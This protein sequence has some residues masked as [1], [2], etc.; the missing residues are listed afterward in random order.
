MDIIYLEPDATVAF[1]AA[2]IVRTQAQ[3]REAIRGIQE[4][5]LIVTIQEEL[6]PLRFRLDI[7][8]AENASLHARIKTTEAIK[9]ITRKHERHA[10]V[11]IEPQLVV[12]QESQRQD[13]E[14]FRK[15]KELEKHTEDENLEWYIQRSSAYSKI[16]L[17]SGYYQLRVRE[18][19]ILK[20]VFRTQYGYYEFR[21]K[22][23]HEEHLKLI[24]ELLK[25][26]QFYAKFSKYEFWI[27]KVQFLGH[28][29]NSQGIHV[30]PGDK[31]EA[32]FQLIKQKLCS[33]PILALPEGSEDFIVY[34]DASIKGLGS[35]LMQREKVIAYG[36]R[37]LKVH[38]KNYTTHD[39]ELGA[40]VFA[41][42][43]WRH[44]LYGTKCTVKANIVAD[45]VSKKKQI[46]PLQVRALVMAIS[47]DLPKQILEAQ[48]EARKPK[49]LKSEDVGGFPIRGALCQKYQPPVCWAN[50][51][52][53]QLIGPKLIHEITE[54]II[55]I[56]QGIQAARD[57]QRSYANVRRKLLEFQVL[58]KV[59]TVSYRLELPQQ[60]SR[61]HSTFYVYNLKK[62][63]SDEPLAIS[64]DEIH[65]DDKICF[66]EESVE[67]IVK[68]LKQSRIPIIKVQWN[69]KR[70]LEFIRE[71]E[72]QFWKKYPHF[73]KKITP[74]TNA[75]S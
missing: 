63:L 29:I 36:S 45:T 7:A 49:N 75:A 6:T 3:Q 59:E 15:L 70:G 38:K 20:T 68:R 55:Q 74:S 16:D 18:E 56:K 43:I 31:Q 26:E 23:E 65:I 8:K 39:L 60:L 52:D 28:V 67:I 62:C 73:F 37:Q 11:E 32:T 34:C 17:R 35:V 51:G 21:C 1:P 64:L 58:A 48:N 57:H 12:V 61:V 46:K 54:K 9:K 72:D 25:K 47:L 71:R 53:A 50:V 41:L 40:V 22:Q 19:D 4:K 2:V 10:R 24:L 42:K 66:V 5:L 27:P 14:N 44:Y 30:D 69:S 13:L 33:A